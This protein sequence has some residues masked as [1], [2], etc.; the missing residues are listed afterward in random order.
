LESNVSTPLGRD[1]I[2]K[3]LVEHSIA[4]AR[5]NALKTAI[6]WKYMKKVVVDD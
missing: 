2:S 1:I 5:M 3:Q 4:V 6:E